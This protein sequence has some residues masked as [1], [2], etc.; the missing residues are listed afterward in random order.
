MKALIGSLAGLALIA[1]PVIA[2]QTTSKAPATAT[3]TAKASTASK[4]VA[5]QAKA[6]RE[7]PATEAKEHR[8]AARRH[9]H[10]AARCSCSSYKM[11]THKARH[12]M[13]KASTNKAPTATKTK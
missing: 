13:A 5:R 10:R 3:K 9:H 8:A 7:S 12:H 2:A 6:E 4:S 1:T 11:K